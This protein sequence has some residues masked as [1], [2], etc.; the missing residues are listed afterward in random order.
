MPGPRRSMV[1]RPCY[2]SKRVKLARQ[3]QRASG[4]GPW[5]TGWGNTSLA[6]GSR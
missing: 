5:L 3:A 2:R 6:P 1:G 4:V